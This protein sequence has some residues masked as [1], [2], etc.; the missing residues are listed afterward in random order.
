MSRTNKIQVRPQ[1]NKDRTRN[2]REN[3]DY[4]KR[5]NSLSRSY[6]GQNVPRTSLKCW[7]QRSTLIRVCPLTGKYNNGHQTYLKVGMK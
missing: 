1:N 6:E 3:N 5:N 2:W 4:P 7:K